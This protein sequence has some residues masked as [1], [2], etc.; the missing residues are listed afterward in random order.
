M[1]IANIAAALEK[2][3][4]AL[5]AFSTAAE[6]VVFMPVTGTPYQILNLLIN[7][8]VDHAVTF[9]VTEQRGIFQISLMYPLGAGR[10]PAQA[11]AQAIADHF[12]PAQDLVESGTR[13][14]I[15]QTV[16]IGQGYEDS[17]RWRVPVSV[18][19]NSFS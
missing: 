14:E 4:A 12:A 13:V 5:G 6:N 15:R 11:R 8:P 18:Y 2:K 3:L 1:S 17:G 7:N 9:D 16:K 19:W 10:G